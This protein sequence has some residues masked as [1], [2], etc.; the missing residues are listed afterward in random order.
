MEAET[1]VT[2]PEAEDAGVSKSWK[3]QDR[4]SPRAFRR[5][6]ALPISQTCSFRTVRELIPVVLS[7]PGLWALLWQPQD[8]HST[9]TCS[10]TG[11]RGF[12]L[13]HFPGQGQNQEPGL[14]TCGEIDRPTL[15]G[16]LVAPAYGRAATKTP[17][18][19]LPDRRNAQSDGTLG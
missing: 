5:S 8:T 10:G 17:S 14:A 6:A 12:L 16:W 9:Q 7:P 1:R 3:R 2:R 11:V 19:R 15:P 13:K 18:W 4:S